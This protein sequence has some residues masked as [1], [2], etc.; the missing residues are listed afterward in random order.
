MQ[1]TPPHRILTTSFFPT[2]IVRFKTKAV[3]L[4]PGGGTNMSP[5]L[6]WRGWLG[7]YPMRMDRSNTQVQSPATTFKKLGDGG[8]PL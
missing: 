5:C 4:L 3:L 1:L 7:N 8:A 2:R 6:I